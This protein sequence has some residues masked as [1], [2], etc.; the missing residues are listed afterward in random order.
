MGA[1][2]C[3]GIT[4]GYAPAA[5]FNLEGR[6]PPPP[7]HP[8]HNNTSMLMHST[9]SNHTIVR[10]A[11]F[12]LLVSLLICFVDLIGNNIFSKEESVNQPNILYRMR[13]ISQRTG[14]KAIGMKAY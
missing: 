5:N 8:A 13:R 14:Q 2:V 7:P 6:P 4:R 10:D 1:I 3:F 11:V 9:V 12:M